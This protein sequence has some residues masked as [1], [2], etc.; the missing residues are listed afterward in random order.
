MSNEKSTSLKPTITATIGD[1]VFTDVVEVTGTFGL[2]GIP[3]CTLTVAVGRTADEIP[4]TIHG[5]L[6]NLRTGM[7]VFVYGKFEGRGEINM[8]DSLVD[9]AFTVFEGRYT[10]MSFSRAGNSVGIKLH[11]THWLNDLNTTS[12]TNSNFFP[13]SPYNAN[14]AALVPAGSGGYG[15]A[16][17]HLVPGWVTEIPNR[18]QIDTWKQVLHP[19]LVFMAEQNKLEAD[20]SLLSHKARRT[21]N[22]LALAALGRMT[23]FRA[24]ARYVPLAL[25]PHGADTVT[26]GD[27]LGAALSQ[28]SIESWQHNTLWGKLIGEWF[29]LLML[30]VA[31]RV[32][33]AVPIPCI[34]PLREY[35]KTIKSDEYSQFAR[36]ADQPQVLLGVGIMHGVM[37]SSGADGLGGTA[38]ANPAF[39]SNL[40]GW[41]PP[42]APPNVEENGVIIV[43][44]A[45]YWLA[46]AHVEYS[47][48][49]VDTTGAAGNPIGGVMAPG[50]GPAPA[51][52][53][54]AA[55]AATTGTFLDE[56]ARYW[57]SAESIRGRTAELAG[58]LRFDIAPG[59]QVRIEGRG[60]AFVEGDKTAVPLHAVVMQVSFVL[61]SQ[62]LQAGTAFSLAHIRTESENDNALF[63]MDTPPLYSQPWLGAPLVDTF[64]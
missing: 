38:D 54:P 26:I 39:L 59:S 49:A 63:V 1:I 23:D 31:P 2:S 21:G 30:C 10:G 22:G 44:N 43:K 3:S 58:K 4:A 6:D 55:G 56:Y 16:W 46:N 57:F 50:V 40:A 24:G 15:G 36:V 5:A 62:T 41:Y 33:D 32:N 61:N 45:P 18:M 27:G 34:C 17:T 28:A 64:N 29:P 47:R 42:E 37:S 12:G 7:K 9:T 53:S 52:P 60:E 8:H 14:T 25:R 13:G 48:F 51:G 35:F 11:V 19:W 20:N